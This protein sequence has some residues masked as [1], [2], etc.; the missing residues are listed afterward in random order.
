MIKA[1][2]Y[3]ARYLYSRGVRTVF[4]LPGGMI[5][6][7]LNS[8]YEFEKIRVLSVHHE[9]AAA[10]A[11]DAAGR[12]T[13]VPGVA[14]ATSGPGAIN[15]LTGIGSCHFDSSPAVFITGQ[16]NRHEL[17]GDRAIRQ[18]GFQESD[19]VSMST[20]ITKA[21][22]QVRTPEELPE[23]LKNAFDLAVAGRPGPVL[24]DIPMDIQNSMLDVPDPLEDPG[25]GAVASSIDP[26]QWEQLSD[27][28]KGAKKPLV[29]AGAGIRAGNALEEFHAFVRKLGLPVVNSLLAVDVMPYGDPLRV[30]MIG[31]Y[32]N[33][34]ANHALAS[35]DLLIVLGSRLD[36]RQT[37][38]DT[39]FFK[40]D[41]VI[42]HVDC[43]TGEIN[44][45]IPGCVAIVSEL[46]PF[47]K[48]A[49]EQL[50]DLAHT[51]W[52]PWIDEI[53]ALREKFDD[54]LEL[55]TATGINPNVFM[56]QLSAASH[57]AGAYLVDVGQHQMWA[58][59]SIE[60]Q[61]DQ[62]WL[63]S[64]G[65]GSMGFALPA[66]LGAAVA[67][68]PRPVVVI[69]GDGAFQCNIQELQTIVRNRLPVKIIVVNNHCHG[70][71]RQFQQS[72]FKEQYQ[73]TLWGYST[74]DFARVAE[75]FGIR[76]VSIRN[77][78][79][80]AEGLRALWEDPSEPVLIDLTIDTFT[81]VYPK[82]A[83]GRPLTEMEP[84]AQPIAMEST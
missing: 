3:V 2:D 55:G 1:T 50:G 31:S 6:H 26:L 58:A 37:G 19:I 76:G 21:S 4:E 61:A 63:T 60:V 84:D 38:N 17:R 30:G 53:T 40:G 20:P 74:P 33:R 9:Q 10:F 14:M 16:V 56:H 29:L 49:A 13:G 18:L 77:E 70:M 47:L 39:S 43:E 25:T 23:V 11:A 27:A 28:L 75:A 78:G 71:V 54:R 12:I 34:W 36:I 24:V 59:Q 32:A 45:R 82:I 62:R 51:D 15:L 35:S 8:L 79:E 66:A 83:F 73:S 64:G 65:M 22:W 69:A 7:L 5:T 52:T 80:V 67:L 68:A 48:A 81:N 41:R 46:R 44:N 72:Y 57:Q 42:V